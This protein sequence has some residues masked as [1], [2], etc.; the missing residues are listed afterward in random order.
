MV[1]Q[2]FLWT[3]DFNRASIPSSAFSQEDHMFYY[4]DIRQYSGCH[5][6]FYHC[7]CK[8]VQR[9]ACLGDHLS[10]LSSLAGGAAATSAGPTDW[11]L[12]GHAGVCHGGGPAFCGGC[13]PEEPRVCLGRPG[14]HI[15][16]Q[17]QVITHSPHIPPPGKYAWDWMIS[18]LDF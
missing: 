1:M 8:H 18:A 16:L 14:E 13:E 12:C 7:V 17:V 3:R 6:Y 15:Q 11:P 9:V 10:Y 5:L 4:A 2:R